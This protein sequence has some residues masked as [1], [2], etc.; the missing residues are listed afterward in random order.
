[1][2]ATAWA[3]LALSLL[4]GSERH[5]AATEARSL[6][7]SA[8]R[9]ELAPDAAA[10]HTLLAYLARGGNVATGLLRD[11][12]DPRAGVG[13]VARFTADLEV[14]P[15]G[16]YGTVQGA[17]DAALALGGP[18]RRYIALHPGTYRERVCVPAHAP[19]IT[20]YGL[21][22]DASEV[23]IAFDDY[24]GKPKAAASGDNPCAPS[25]EGPTIGTRA[26]ATFTAAAPEF[27]A[28][29]VSFVND[30]NEAVI[31]SRSI[32]A[33]ALTAEGDRQIFESVRVLGNQDSLFLNTPEVGVVTRAYF[34]HCY[35][36]GDT[37]FIFGR[38]AAVL[39]GCTIHSLSARTQSG[40]ILAPSTDARVEHGILITNSV[41]TADAGAAPASI[42]LGR[43]W[44]EGQVDVPTYAGHVPSGVFPNGQALV[45]HSELGPHLQREAPWRPA[46]TTARPY[47]SSAGDLP[48]NRLYE[49]DNTGPGS[50][51]R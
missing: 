11:D 51:A 33:V 42:H 22:R 44:D 24:A 13:D 43:A 20:L 10:E 41:F 6:R 15:G 48:A 21:G 46:A 45:H 4:A 17:I 32:Q 7:A 16:R 2:R 19:P 12:W 34:T 8:T 23:V 35:V 29:N 30:T 5:P 3:L 9:P 37:D 50:R 31:E 26:S 25:P 1:M 49:L 47:R 14:A 28:K 39:D 36:E 18:M 27:Q 40:V 38:A